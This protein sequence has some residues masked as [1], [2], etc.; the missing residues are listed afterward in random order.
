MFQ[1]LTISG[2]GKNNHDTC[3]KVEKGY[4]SHFGGNVTIEDSNLI[5]DNSKL[6]S[7]NII[8]TPFNQIDEDEQTVGVM[9]TSNGN[10][11]EYLGEMVVE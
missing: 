11:D 9:M 10:W 5:L 7:D 2:S 6:V 8:V 3:F 1:T 4:D